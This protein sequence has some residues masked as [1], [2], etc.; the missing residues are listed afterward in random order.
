MGRPLLQVCRPVRRAGDR[1]AGDQ[2]RARPLLR[3]PGQPP[4]LDQ[5]PAREGRGR[6]AAD[7][8]VRARNREP[9]RLGGLCAVRVAAGRAAALRLCPAAAPGPGHHRAGATRS[10]GPRAAQGVAPVD[11]RGR[12]GHR[13]LDRARLRRSDGPQGLVRAGLLPQGK[14]ALL[15]HGGGPRRPQRRDGRGGQ[16]QADL[17]RRLADQDRPRR[18]RLCRRQAGPAGGPSRHLAGAARHR[19]EP[20]VPSVGRPLAAHRRRRSG[21]CAQPVRPVGP[22]GPRRHPGARLDRVRRAADL[23]GPAARDRRRPA[24]PRPAGAGPDHRGPRRRPAGAAHG[25]A[26]PYPAGRRP[27]HRQRRTRPSA[28]HQ[29]RRRTGG[30]GQP[31]QPLGRGTRGVLRH[32]RAAGRGPDR[33]TARDARTADRDGR[34]PA[35]HLPVANRCRARPAGRRLCSAAFLRCR[36]RNDRPAR[37]QRAG[38]DRTC[39][40]TRSASRCAHSGRYDLDHRAFGA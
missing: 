8:I 29:D 14:R 7:R 15:H 25:G 4:R 12:R 24:H 38:H 3:L 27:A 13:S 39:G 28:E 32:A 21:R 34:D 26:D 20:P 5:R 31:V 22:V 33:R 1:R 35:G 18:L 30:A 36:R 37:G 17:G 16:S 9:D 40:H 23:R 6:G 11:G 2:R 19:H 10:P